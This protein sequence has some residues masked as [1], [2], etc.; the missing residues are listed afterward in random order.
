MGSVLQ[1]SK[2]WPLAEIDHESPWTFMVIHGL[3]GAFSM[4]IHEKQR[5]HESS[6]TKLQ[7]FSWTLM[8]IAY[9]LR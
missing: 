6:W 3:N 7:T 8:D 1:A 4:I 2:R 5:I 9:F